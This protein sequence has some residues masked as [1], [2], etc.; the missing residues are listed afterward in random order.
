MCMPTSSQKASS[1]KSNKS[2]LL[3]RSKCASFHRILW[4]EIKTFTPRLTTTCSTATAH[5]KTGGLQLCWCKKQCT[6]QAARKT[7]SGTTQ[8][9]SAGIKLPPLSFPP[10]VAETHST[11]RSL[12]PSLSRSNSK[13]LTASWISLNPWSPKSSWNPYLATVPTTT[14]Q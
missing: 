10:P 6:E 3:S 5:N 4:K 11:T 13:S 8:G 12:A 7:P 2:C 9:P 1:Q 14:S